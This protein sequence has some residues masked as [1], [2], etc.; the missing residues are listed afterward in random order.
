MNSTELFE[1]LHQFFQFLFIVYVYLYIPFE[2]AFFCLDRHGIDIDL[3]FSRNQV[4]DLIYDPDI[5]HSYDPDACKE[6]YFFVFRPFGLHDAM[7]VIGHQ[8]RGIGAIRTMYGKSLPYG[9]ESEHVIAGDGLAAVCQ[10]I[11]DPVAALPE[12]DQ[13][14]VLTGD[15]GG[16]SIR[17]G[18]ENRF[19]RLGR[20]QPVSQQ[21]K[22]FQL[23]KID[24]PDGHLVEEVQGGV[25]LIESGQYID[26]MLIVGRPEIFQLALNDIF[27]LI[28]YLPFL[29][30]QGILDLGFGLGGH[31]D[32]NPVFI[33]F[34]LAGSDDLHLVAAAQLMTDGDQF[35][36]DLGPDGL[37]PDGAM[38]GKGKIQRGGP[39]RQHLHIPFR[40]VYIDL[41]RQETVL[42]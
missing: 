26:I 32:I 39:Y 5:I 31:Y 30:F 1:P 18:L 34:L 13:F 7:S 8:F 20:F 21:V 42:T 24:V 29:L 12:N 36:I 16:G 11:D 23:L 10:R 15:L 25:E 40:G 19:G 28:R 2:E 3:Q 37:H 38:D 9:Y 35:V 22:F 4:G 33:G 14:R 41:F 17:S 6:R 27:S